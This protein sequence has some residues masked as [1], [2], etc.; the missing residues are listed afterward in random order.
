[1][2]GVEGTREGVKAKHR[3]DGARDGDEVAARGRRGGGERAARGRRGQGLPQTSPDEHKWRAEA[4][5][6]SPWRLIPY[7][8]PIF[9]HILISAGAGP[10]RAL[11]G[12]RCAARGVGKG[13]RRGEASQLS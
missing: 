2:A 5:D 3:G 8:N 4:F 13:A 10:G 12:S 11:M 1:M 7:S 9:C 6:A